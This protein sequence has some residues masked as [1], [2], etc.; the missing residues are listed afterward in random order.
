MYYLILIPARKNSKRIKNKNLINFNG[1]SLIDRSI[2]EALKIKYKNLIIVSSDH[3][4]ILA[5]SKLYSKNNIKFLKRPKYLS[6]DNSSIE[7]LI[8]YLL[9]K[10]FKDNLPENIII[11][12]PTSPLRS[13]DHINKCI[14]KYEREK[15]DSIFSVYKDKIFLW[16]NKFQSITYNYRKRQNTQIMKDFYIENGAIFIFKT[17]KFL[18]LKNKRRIFG[19][20]DYFEMSKHSS[21]DIDN[22]ED[23]KI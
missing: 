23:L 3:E 1:V 19:K 13:S 9:G 15:L 14:K 4:K 17:T 7:D 18:K 2:K 22:Y 6:L 16:N 10:E 12:Q 20:F 5:K 8:L 21:K 11:L